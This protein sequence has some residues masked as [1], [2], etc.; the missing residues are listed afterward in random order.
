MLA[1]QFANIA[2]Q[3]ED[4]SKAMSQALK[5]KFLGNVRP[6]YH[7]VPQHGNRWMY[8]RSSGSQERER[9]KC[10]SAWSEILTTSY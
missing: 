4:T 8:Y 7:L 10:W 3:E 6:A 9:E 1:Q 5:S 2:E